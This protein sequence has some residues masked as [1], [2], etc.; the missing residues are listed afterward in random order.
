MF[1]QA[2]FLLGVE[3]RGRGA[4]DSSKEIVLLS[5]IAAPGRERVTG[6][7]EYMKIVILRTKTYGNFFLI[8]IIYL[9]SV[10]IIYRF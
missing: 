6:I 10:S 8:R 4:P 7:N 3:A 1:F 5:S 9:S 2:V